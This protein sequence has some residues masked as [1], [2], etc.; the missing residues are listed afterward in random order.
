MIKQFKTGISFLIVAAALLVAA[1]AIIW[2]ND[3]ARSITELRGTVL[4]SGANQSPKNAISYYKMR[5]FVKIDDG[6]H[7]GVLSERRTAPS[8]GD[9]ITVQE[10]LGWFGTTQF[11]EIPQM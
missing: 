1:F 10:R 9:R 2:F 8:I 11:V 3:P 4:G 5:L 7:V 6:R